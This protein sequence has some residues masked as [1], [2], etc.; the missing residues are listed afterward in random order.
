MSERVEWMMIDKIDKRLVINLQRQKPV[1]VE[2][3]I[4]GDVLSFQEPCWVN[5]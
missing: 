5:N 1:G 3:E 4:V 2:E